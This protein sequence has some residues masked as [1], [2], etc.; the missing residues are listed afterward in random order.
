MRYLMIAFQKP[1]AQASTSNHVSRAGNVRFVFELCC[2]NSMF[3]LKVLCSV[4][5]PAG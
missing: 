1:S 4:L 3:A 5:L 2:E